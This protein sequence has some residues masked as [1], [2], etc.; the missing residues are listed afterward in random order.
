MTPLEG[1]L[2]IALTGQSKDILIKQ[3]YLTKT[4]VT[5]YS[6]KQLQTT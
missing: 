6:N 4:L 2:I 1:Q 5:T 3:T